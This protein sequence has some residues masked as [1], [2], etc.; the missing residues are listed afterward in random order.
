MKT[1]IGIILLILA[2]AALILTI[3]T[4]TVTPLPQG[5]LNNK[6]AIGASLGVA[7]GLLLI[8]GV[9]LWILGSRDAQL[10][11]MRKRSS[12]SEGVYL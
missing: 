1:V 11:D 3:V 10:A 5:W 12:S 7:C 4:F 8:A 2:A 6:I 9:T